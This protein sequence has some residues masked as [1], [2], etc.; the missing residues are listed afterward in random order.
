MR[1]RGH[2]VRFIGALYFVISLL[3]LVVLLSPSLRRSF[4]RSIKR[5]L[6][7]R[8]TNPLCASMA[9]ELNRTSSMESL[10]RVAQVEA[11]VCVL[12]RTYAKQFRNL[13]TLILNFAQDR[14][15]TKVFIT[16]TDEDSPWEPV[17]KMTALLNEMV[18]REVAI[19][20]PVKSDRAKK[21]W[22]QPN[23]GLDYGY[24]YTDA[25]IDMMV[26]NDVPCDYALVTNGD[27]LY[28][29]NFLE[30]YTLPHM[31]E[32]VDL[33]AFDY[34]EHGPLAWTVESGDQIVD[35][36]TLKPVNFRWAISMCDLG[37]LLIKWSWFRDEGLRF[38]K[39]AVS[40]EDG[41]KDLYSADGQ[42][43]K[44]IESLNASKVLI[45]QTLFLHQ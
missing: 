8:K 32:E 31:L 5:A 16:I 38:V 35:D 17:L 40:L 18:G 24:T 7:I 21:I 14:V 27:N 1:V 25:A 44:L 19:V 2:Q 45:R 20:L 43:I 41:S 33:I 37:A 34:I 30:R 6:T 10:F 39:D 9:S 22:V 36:G 15:H 13:P 28:S 26:A 42:M 11:Q 12:V 23:N 3:F 29:S 4:G